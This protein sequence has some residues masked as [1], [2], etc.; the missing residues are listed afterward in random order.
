M[1]QEQEKTIELLV[2]EAKKDKNIIGVILIGSLAKNTSTKNSDVDVLVIVNDIEFEK[3]KKQKNY[4]LGT[5]FEPS[6][7]PVEIE[8]K[9]INKDYLKRIWKDGNECVKNT[10]S[11]IKILYSYDKEIDELLEN[12]DTKNIE[13]EENIKKF[14][15]LMKSYRFKSNDD[16]TNIIQIKHGIF[17][18]V[19]FACRLVLEHNDI[20]YP[21]IKNIEKELV[22][23]IKKPNNFIKNI[24]R[25]LETYSLEEM[26]IFYNETEEYFKEYRFD[27]RIRKGYVI[28]NE[29][30]WFFDVR[31]YSEI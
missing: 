29:E 8:G 20:Y 13:K 24:H 30:Y 11:K 31:P 12:M 22:N 19:Y 10:F 21:C 7:F 15:A 16:L 26:E 6:M 27:D 14:Y 23:C 5:N 25:V 17:S 4:F 1:T 28:E 3:R 2:K 9:I 18:T